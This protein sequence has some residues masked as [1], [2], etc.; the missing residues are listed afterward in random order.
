MVGK[1]RINSP[2]EIG[3]DQQTSLQNNTKEPE[4]VPKGLL[5]STSGHI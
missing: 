5:E 3:E 1:K 2:G 4:S